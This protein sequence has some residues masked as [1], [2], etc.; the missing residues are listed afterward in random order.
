MAWL[1]SRSYTLWLTVALFACSD[2]M[3]GSPEA[4]ESFIENLSS[5]LMPNVSLTIA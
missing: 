2:R 1:A 4:V 3:I 5:Q